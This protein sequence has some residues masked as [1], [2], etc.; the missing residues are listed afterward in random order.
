VVPLFCNEDLGYI[1]L[2]LNHTSIN[3]LG[4]STNIHEHK[5]SYFIY[6]DK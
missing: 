2:V 3:K 4:M 5:Y 1:V 6:G